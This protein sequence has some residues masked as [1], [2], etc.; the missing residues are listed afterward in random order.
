MI[1]LKVSGPNFDPLIRSVEAMAH[2][3]LMPLALKVAAIMV[4]DNRIGLLASTDSFGDPMT[5]LEPSTIRRGRGGD[6]PP[7]IPRGEAS[8]LISDYRVD[9]RPDDDRT[10]LV[11]TWPDSPFVHF[12]ATGT[13]HMVSRDP[14]GIR[15]DGQALIEEAVADF[16]QTLI[17]G[18][19]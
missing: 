12:H 10:L 4:E 11:G 16:A 2:P 1:R 7:L 17:G 14:V 6:G 5:E 15:P 13:K 8:R 18:G 3:H 9:I 19:A